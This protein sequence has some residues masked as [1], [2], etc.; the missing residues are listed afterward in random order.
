VQTEVS[1]GRPV[2][3]EVKAIIAAQVIQR[4]ETPDDLAGVAVFLASE[5]ARFVTGQ[6]INVDGG[7][8]FD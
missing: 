3:E 6:V 1:A 5:D 8:N 4:R 2:R 7:L